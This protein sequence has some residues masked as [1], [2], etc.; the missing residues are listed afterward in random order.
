MRALL[1]VVVVACGTRTESTEVVVDPAATPV[2]LDGDLRDGELALTFDDGPDPDTTRRILATLAAHGVRATFFQVG[3][4]AEAHP[5]VTAEIVEQGHS[6][7]S[8]SFDHADLSALPLDEAIANARRGHANATMPFFRF[9]FLR[10]S[11]PL[12]D[13]MREQG[14]ATFHANIITE[15]HATPDPAE[16]LAKSLAAVDAQGRGIVLFHDIQPVTAEILGAFLAEIATRGY[17]T[18]VFVS[19]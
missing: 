13:A 19:P 2:L 10:S 9:P 7:G 8:H 14:F 6:V 18:V 1:L 11:E 5:D 16:L 3:R 12:L 4:N 15:D 17:Q